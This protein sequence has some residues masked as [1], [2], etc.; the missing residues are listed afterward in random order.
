MEE[1]P[2]CQS[3]QLLY[4]KGLNNEK[5]IH[6]N[7]QLKVAAAHAGDRRRLFYLI[8]EKD[9]STES[10]PKQ[11]EP[12]KAA[13]ST[14]KAANPKEEHKE[15][16]AAEK[17]KIG[18]PIPFQQEETHSFSE[19]LKL[20]EARPIVRKEEEKSSKSLSEKVDLIASFIAKERPKPSKE[21]FFS[22]SEKAKKS[23]QDEM[24]FVTETLARVYL[25][26]GHYQKAKSAYQSLS[27]KYPEKSSFFAGQIKLI[28]E[29]INKDK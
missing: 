27:L 21:A 4:V 9:K 17:L 29:L 16:E 11:A 14:T 22:P 26:Q 8:T 5:S 18:Q 6:F 19:W 12:P 13:E 1:H 24:S 23:V 25:E 15:E 7:Q 10:K 28:E 2:Y 20:S 3:L